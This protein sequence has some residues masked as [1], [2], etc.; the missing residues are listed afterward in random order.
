MLEKPDLEFGK[1]LCDCRHAVHM[2]KGGQAEHGRIMPLSA[3]A[4]GPF[5]HTR[6]EDGTG[7]PQSTVAM[8]PASGAH[9]PKSKTEDNS[10]FFALLPPPSALLLK[11]ADHP[12]P[13]LPEMQVTPGAGLRNGW[14][15]EETSIHLRPFFSQGAPLGENAAVALAVSVLACCSSGLRKPRGAGACGKHPVSYM[16]TDKICRAFLP[17]Y[18]KKCHT[19]I[20]KKR[21]TIHIMRDFLHIV[22]IIKIILGGYFCFWK[23]GED[24]LFPIPPGEHQPEPQYLVHKHEEGQRPTSLPPSM[25]PKADN[26]GV[27]GRDTYESQG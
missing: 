1:A 2:E 6:K 11:V 14:Q 8:G 18:T 22:N 21:K 26:W 23:D 12:G 9:P 15:L 5:L 10:P 3:R 24:M 25:H 27:P 7:P 13:I 16:Q 19:H 4:R 20:A 17:K